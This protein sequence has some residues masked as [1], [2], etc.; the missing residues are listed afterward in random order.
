MG[1]ELADLV[2]TDPPY[3]VDVTG[4]TKENLKIMNDSMS[5]DS[6]VEFLSL[7]FKNLT[8]GLKLGGAGIYGLLQLNIRNLKRPFQIIRC[9]ST[10]S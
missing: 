8:D 5:D 6:F 2:V 10:S 9:M 7:A 1:K 3:N 4:G